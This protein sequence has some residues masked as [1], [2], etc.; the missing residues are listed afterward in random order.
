[1]LTDYVKG[2]LEHLLAERVPRRARGEGARAGSGSGSP[3]DFEPTDDEEWLL[4]GSNAEPPPWEARTLRVAPPL[5]TA[6]SQESDLGR[7]RD[8]LDDADPPP[9]RPF[10][11]SHL[12]VVGALL[13]IGLLCAGWSVLRARPVAIASTPDLSAPT[14]TAARSGPT[15]AATTSAK[16]PTQIMVHVLG[17]VHRPG[18]VSLAERARVRDAI[19]AAGGLKRDAAPGE[20]NLAQVLADGQQI[21]IGTRKKPTGEVREG[22][23][24]GTTDTSSGTADPGAGTVDLNRASQSQLEEL[25]GVGPVTAAKIV[26]WRE[27]HSR[28]SKVEELQEI[29]GIG[30]KTYAEIAPHVRV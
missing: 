29:D 24:S 6:R 11:R 26:A 9:R 21:M 10:R 23:G 27:E 28:F 18:V 16:Q 5:S 14:A 30:P 4:S 1:M 12:A 20:L 25:P 13:L 22:S 3:P 19:E 8:V 15:A 2:R 17:A 7:Q